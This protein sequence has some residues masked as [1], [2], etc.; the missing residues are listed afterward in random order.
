MCAGA[1]VGYIVLH[2]ASV[3]IYDK[4]GPVFVSLLTSAA[5]AFDLSHIWMA[6]YF[7]FIGGAFG[8][9]HGLNHYRTA[10]LYAKVKRLS[11]TDALTGL[12]NRR[13]LTECLN[14]EY[15]RSERYNGE[16]SLIMIDIDH[17]KNYNDV[18]GH[19][20]G[21]RLLQAMAGRIRIIAR[22][23]D[24]VARYGGEEFVILMPD[25][26]ISMAI[27]LAERLRRDIASFPFENR[28]TQPEGK[29]TISVGCAQHD[30]GVGAGVDQLIRM[31]DDCLY[32]AKNRGRN[33]I[34]Y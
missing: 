30:E 28:E 1:A 34:W 29:V 20:A 7:A 5:S 22:K 21:D 6:M 16:L 4:L 9:I 19:Q 11:I 17:F 25:T 18:H 12:F 33:K 31:A 3:I 24:I 32:R 10:I 8:L 27:H 23:T 14:R 26:P 13:F 15:H 2:P